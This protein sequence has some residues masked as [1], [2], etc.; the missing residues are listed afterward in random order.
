MS[1]ILF[2]LIVAGLIS[3]QPQTQIINAYPT[4]SACELAV[5]ELKKE[6][7]QDGVQAISFGCIEVR[8]VVKASL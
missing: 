3:G 4:K 7:L 8:P 1:S 2:V 6:E 5:S